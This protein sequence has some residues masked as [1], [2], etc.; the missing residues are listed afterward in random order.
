MLTNAIRM[1]CISFVVLF[2]LNFVYLVGFLK[3]SEGYK[4]KEFITLFRFLRNLRK[5]TQ[6][7]VRILFHII[8]KV[9]Y[10]RSVVYDSLRPHRLQHARLPCPTPTSGNYSNHIH[11][12]RDAIQQSHHLL[13]PSSPAFNLSQ[14]QGLFQ[15]VSSSHQAA[16]GLEFQLQHQSFQC[17]F[18]TDFL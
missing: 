6:E 5:K 10:S 16:K 12:V 15:W 13:S 7:F 8:T 11:W 17:I 9:Q 2:A 14:H 1:N 18:R 4:Y 3:L